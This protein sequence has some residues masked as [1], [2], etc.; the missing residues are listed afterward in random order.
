VYTY[1]DGI[2][3]MPIYNLPSK[4]LCKVVYVQLKVHHFYFSYFIFYLL[5]IVLL[6]WDFRLLE[7]DLFMEFFLIHLV[8]QAEADTDEV[9]AQITLIPVSEVG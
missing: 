7:E 9:F 3:E 6:N 1:E 5:L 8:L 4:I 2:M